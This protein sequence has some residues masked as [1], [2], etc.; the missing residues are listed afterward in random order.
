[1]SFPYLKSLELYIYLS[2]NFKA[3]ALPL[4]PTYKPNFENLHSFV[5]GYVVGQ[6]VL[7][8]FLISFMLLCR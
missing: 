7:Y 8:L 5:K 6:T 4:L 2:P 3:V 1:M